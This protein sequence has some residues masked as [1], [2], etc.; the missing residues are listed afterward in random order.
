MPIKSNFRSRMFPPTEWHPELCVNQDVVEEFELVEYT[1]WMNRSV[2]ARHQFN[3]FGIETINLDSKALSW[4]FLRVFKTQ[5][6]KARK[7]LVSF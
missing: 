1:L 2:R 4:S 5:F 6:S 7:I 3:I